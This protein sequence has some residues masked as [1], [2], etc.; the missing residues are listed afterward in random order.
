MAKIEELKKLDLDKIKSAEL[1][2]EIQKILDDFEQTDQD[3]MKEFL[4]EAQP[5]IDII[6]DVVQSKYPDAIPGKKASKTKEKADSDEQP[7]ETDDD[8]EA[9]RQA[10]RDKSKKTIM[11]ISAYEQEIADCRQMIK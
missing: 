7:E 9:H 4:S 5:G 3:D 1:K 6:Y 8:A 2:Q 10:R 11:S